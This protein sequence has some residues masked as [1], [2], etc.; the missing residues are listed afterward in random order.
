M[1]D[2]YYQILDFIHSTATIPN[3]PHTVYKIH[4]PVRLPHNAE[5]Q[6][7]LIDVVC[8]VNVCAAINITANRVDMEL[9]F[10]LGFAICF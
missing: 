8:S 2:V 9:N 5:T 3:Q 1:G 10:S 4:V 6:I 7:P